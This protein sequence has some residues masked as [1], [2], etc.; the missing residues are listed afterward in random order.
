M[1]FYPKIAGI[2]AQQVGNIQGKVTSQVQ[3]EVFKI[4]SKF[5]NQCPSPKEIANIVKI[6][7]TL[8]KNI[9][10]LS[11]RV[12]TLK[13]IADKLNTAITA[14][15]LVIQ[16]LKTTPLPTT[17]GTPPGPAGGVIFS[18]T[19]GKVVSVGDRLATVN[20]LL[21]SLESDR[22]GILG[23]IS[24][25]SSTLDSLRNRLSAIDLAVQE[26]SQE[27]PNLASILAELQPK[28]NTGT[29]GTP[30]NAFGEDDP[31]F[32]YKGYKLEIL[33][34]PN[35]PQIAP[36][37]YAVARDRRGIVVLKGPPSFS[38]STDILLDEIKFRIDNQL[39]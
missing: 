14:A 32:S 37:R 16:F 22:A 33:Q 2:V 8:L 29:E 7:N 15:K 39:P 25:V 10:S 11:R 34:D 31:R 1:A 13:T 19:V 20:K 30:Q 28:E 24:S 17:I 6:R 38:S 4:L 26:C 12:N 27:S 3:S 18:L 23:V 36:R 35:S 21:D 9:N 5:S